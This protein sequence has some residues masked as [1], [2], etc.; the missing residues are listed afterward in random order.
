M[1]KFNL[2]IVAF[3]ALWQLS[4]CERSMECPD[5]SE[6]IME[7]YPYHTDNAILFYHDLNYIQLNFNNISI[8]HTTSYYPNL[9]C[10]TCDDVI[11]IY[12]DDYKGHNFYIYA[13]INN[14][15]I[16]YEQY[17]ISGTEFSAQSKDFI[18]E[19]DYA[20]GD[21][22]Y[23]EVRIFNTTT[24][25]ADYKQLIVAK[26]EGIVAIIDNL[27][28]VYALNKNQSYYFDETHKPEISNYVCE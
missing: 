27:D 25:D 18:I 23:D 16:K 28:N 26:G 3:I 14:N 13:F 8:T 2:I 20:I 11:E 24:E 12:N 5:I 6:E 4:A 7:W 9:D 1:R 17:I 15:E 10:G 19:Y 22:V 21:V